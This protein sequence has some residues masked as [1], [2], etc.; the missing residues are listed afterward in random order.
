[1]LHIAL[2]GEVIFTILGY[3]VTNSIFTTW[4]VMLVLSIG[5][6]V[7]SSRVSTVPGRYQNFVE[8]VLNGL[9]G[10][11][12]GVLG[13]RAR[14]FYPLLGTLFIFIIMSN[15]IGLLPG[16]GSIGVKQESAHGS[17]EH[18]EHHEVVED[19][20]HGDV[21]MI[22]EVDDHSMAVEEVHVME[23]SDEHA[24]AHAEEIVTDS[25]HEGEEHVAMTPLLRAPTADLNTTF[26]LAIITF[27]ALQY[28]GIKALGGLTYLGKFINF[29]NPIYF[30]VGILEIVSEFGK[31]ISFAFR[32]FGN[33]FAGEVLLA[34]I[35]FLI[36]L[37][38]P[39]PFLGLE[40]FVGFIQ[41]LV[42]AMLTAVF[43]SAATSHEEH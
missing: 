7:V 30:F 24:P 37:F 10:V 15:W 26:A 13:D 28:S 29:K 19:V 31:I 16:V 34:V 2:S 27:I 36:P 40:I 14:R 35:A 6:I 43:L 18:V 9:M 4:L 1:M 20:G 21:V 42:F 3:P 23:G 17:G 11:F 39:I 41:A 12:S 33:I 5:A 38:A 25:T 32:L 8:V 22:E